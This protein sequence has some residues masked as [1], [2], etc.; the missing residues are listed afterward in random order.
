MTPTQLR[1]Y[2]AVV[3]N[4]SVKGAAAEI[5]VSE[6]AVSL[7]MAQLRKELTDQLF[8]RTSAGLAFTPGG[9]RLASRATEMLGLQDQTIREVNRAGH[10]RRLLRVATTSLFA[11]YCAPGLIDLFVSRA[12]DFEVELSVQGP[13][14]F[15]S[16]LRSRA[17]DVV[18]GPHPAVTPAGLVSK[19]FLNYQVI[20]VVAPGHPLATAPAG[21]ALLREQTWLLGPS[22]A[23]DGGAVPRLLRQL[24]IPEERQRIF[25][26][27][28]AAVEE[29][30]RSN[31][32]ALVVAFAVRDDLVE[33]SLVAVGAPRLQAD[34]VW[35]TL[36]LAEQDLVPAAAELTRFVSTPRALQAML[37]GSGVDVRHFRP[38]VHVTLWK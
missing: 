37:R 38:S 23:G 24:D 15:E 33:R 32:V 26:S 7:H 35:A 18:I 30:K 13:S 34:G 2:S 11:E 10:G 8:T 9:L 28:V 22:A 3:R 17:V 4:G 21:L 36:S 29:A 6:A 12:E 25:Q 14:Q 5:G 1:A 19:P 16:Q 20:A 27:H 31:G